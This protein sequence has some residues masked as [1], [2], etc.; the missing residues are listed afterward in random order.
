MH[1]P[2]LEAISAGKALTVP[3]FFVTSWRIFLASPILWSQLPDPLSNR[4]VHSLRFGCKVA[5]SGRRCCARI[6][7][8]DFVF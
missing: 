8:K 1:F 5:R 3:F 2:A 6:W 4:T 7:T